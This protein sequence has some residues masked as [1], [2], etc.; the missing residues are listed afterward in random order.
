MSCFRLG[1]IASIH[2]QSINITTKT[3]INLVCSFQHS[4]AAQLGRRWRWR[5]S[6][7]KRVKQARR[8]QKRRQS[9]SCEQLKQEVTRSLTLTRPLQW[10]ERENYSKSSPKFSRKHVLVGFFPL[11]IFIELIDLWNKNSADVFVGVFLWCW[12]SNMRPSRC[13]LCFAFLHCRGKGMGKQSEKVQLELERVD[14][15][16]CFGFRCWVDGL[17]IRKWKRLRPVAV[18]NAL[19]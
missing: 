3:S 14:S 11:L 19:H 16:V 18:L 13:W 9:G 8:R 15:K 17:K 1:C 7:K 2:H 4:N 5:R 6:K 12:M 10:H